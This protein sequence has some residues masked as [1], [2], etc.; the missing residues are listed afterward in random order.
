MFHAGPSAHPRRQGRGGQF[1]TSASLPG[2]AQGR[3]EARLWLGFQ[4]WPAS[5]LRAGTNREWLVKF[6]KMRRVHFLGLTSH[7]PSAQWVPGLDSTEQSISVI[8]ESSPGQA[9]WRPGVPAGLRGGG[10]P[11]GNV[12]LSQFGAYWHLEGGG[13]G[14][15]STSYR[16]QGSPL[17]DN[18]PAP[19]VRA[20]K[21]RPPP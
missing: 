7:V 1:V 18:A 14:C 3:R 6:I 8:L 4:P 17:T 2:S 5:A 10:R 19:S 16:A 12:W 21:R 13:W 9:S 11:S 15:W 20:T